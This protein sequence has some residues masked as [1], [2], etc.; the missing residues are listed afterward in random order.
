MMKILNHLAVLSLIFFFQ[1]LSYAVNV[2]AGIKHEGYDRLLKK[3]VDEKGLV[4]YEKWKSN[5]E[6]MKGLDDYLAQIAATG[7]TASAN[8]RYASQVNAY[9]GFVQ[10]WMLKN[11]PTD[12]IGTLKISFNNTRHKLGGATA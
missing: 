12:S 7:N 4:A 8:E 1:P 6:D 11:Y 9:N 3:Y 2:P 5:A 10:Q